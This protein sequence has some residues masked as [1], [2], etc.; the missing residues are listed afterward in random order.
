MK[1]LKIILIILVVLVGAYS[2]WMATIDPEYH[3]K[4]TAVID[5]EPGTVYAT[6]SDFKTW[7]EWSK[8]HKMDPDMEVSYGEKSAGEGATYTWNGEKAGAGT[9]TIT[10]AVPN[11]SMKT[12]IAFEGM[13]ESDGYWKFEP[14][15]GGQTQ[16]TW[17]FTGKMPFF[18]RVFSLGMD[19]SVGADFEEGLA[20]LKTKIET[21]HVAK[22]AASSAEISVVEIESMPYYGIKKELKWEDMGSEFFAQSY[23]KIMDYLG[24][25]A[26][27]NMLMQPFAIYHK[28]DEENK[29]AVVEPALA[30]ESDKPG[31]KEVKK[32]KTYAGK[33][34]KGV[35]KGSYESTGDM[36]NAISDYMKEHK[37]EMA[38]APWE[39]YVTDPMEV[40][41]TAQWVTEI[42]YPV[43]AV[44]KAEMTTNPEK[45]NKG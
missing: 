33:T 38:G 14:T 25:D 13:G 10:E 31:N 16:V 23:E 30:V 22:A 18:F 20:N 45:P 28:W 37:L 4:R 6:V 9:Q 2:I 24:E 5:A 35:H 21:A 42:Y 41:D 40:P 29:M 11:Q 8:W 27:Q 32:G 15:E 36:H 3:V 39:V 34:I 43:V 19:Q 7:S 1:A 12:H 17:G 44:K 26:Q